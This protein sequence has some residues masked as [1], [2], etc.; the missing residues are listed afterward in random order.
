MRSVESKQSSVLLSERF[1]RLGEAGVDERKRL[2]LSKAFD[3]LSRLLGKQ[4]EEL[5][6]AIYANEAGQILLSPEISVPLHEAWLFKNPEAL[7]RVKRGLKEAAVRKL[8]DL[9]SFAKHADNEI[10]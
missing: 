3:W 9:G 10:E 8:V 4:A 1:E 5:R 7:A 2:S 6:F